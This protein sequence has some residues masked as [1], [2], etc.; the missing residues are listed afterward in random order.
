MTFQLGASPD[1]HVAL[2]DAAT[3]EERLQ[4]MARL[5]RA[6]W[7]VS[8]RTWPSCVRAELPGEVFRIDHVARRTP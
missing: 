5:C 6:A 4:A 8:G 7:L 2:Y 3:A 1:E